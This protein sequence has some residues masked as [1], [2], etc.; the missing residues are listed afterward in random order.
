MTDDQ[1]ASRGASTSSD[2]GHSH[3]RN[4]RILVLALDGTPLPVLQGLVHSITSGETTSTEKAHREGDELTAS[5]DDREEGTEEDGAAS[6]VTTREEQPEGAGTRQESHAAMLPWTIDNRYYTADV[7]FRCVSIPLLESD[8][9]FSLRRQRRAASASDPDRTTLRDTLAQELHGVTAII[10]VHGGGASARRPRSVSAAGDS[11]E[12]H[13]SQLSALEVSSLASDVARVSDEVTHLGITPLG[14]ELAVSVVVSLAQRQSRSIAKS[15]LID[16]SGATDGPNQGSR[17]SKEQVVEFYADQG[18]EYVDLGIDLDEVLNGS[19]DPGVSNDDEEHFS[20][21][22]DV[23]YGHD[24]AEGLERVREALE[25]NMWPDLKRKQS[26]RSARVIGFITESDSDNRRRGSAS[27]HSPQ[28]QD[29]EQEE[30]DELEKMLHRMDLGLPMP[31]PT[32]GDFSGKFPLREGTDGLLAS[33]FDPTLTASGLTDDLFKDVQP[34]KEDEDLA[35]KFLAQIADFERST[36]VSEGALRSNLL[37]RELPQSDEERRHNQNEALHRLE[38][39]LASEDPT[40][41]MSDGV[42]DDNAVASPSA[43]TDIGGHVKESFEDDFDGFVSVPSAPSKRRPS[44]NNGNEARFSKAEAWPELDPARWRI[45][46]QDA[47]SSHFDTEGDPFGLVAGM[48]LSHFHSE[49]QRVRSTDSSN[50]NPER[51][52]ES[53]VEHMLNSC[54]LDEG[55]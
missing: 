17:V 46:D 4:D 24:E 21:A 19:S 6:F 33:N 45:G 11:L 54:R 14:F 55:D 31:A 51:E 37:P 49:A 25:A 36:S 38:E 28:S 15:N 22:D 32:A 42:N 13:R 5:G 9:T 52:A 34:T 40:W 23:K 26:S 29:A 8:R 7:H 2:P 41:P 50:G 10:L 16:G 27:E 3:R 39:F 18:W 53:F 12:I 48:S 35:K 43:V 1:R 44:D 20:H 47:T 30:A